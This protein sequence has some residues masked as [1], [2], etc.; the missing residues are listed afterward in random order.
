MTPEKITTSFEELNEK[1][2]HYTLAPSDDPASELED[3]QEYLSHFYDEHCKVEV[4]IP[5]NELRKAYSEKEIGFESIPMPKKIV[6]KSYQEE[7]QTGDYSFKISVDGGEF[8]RLKIRFER[9]EVGDFCGTIINGWGRF[10]KELERAKSNP[11][12][13]DFRIVVEGD[14]LQA[15]AF[16]FPY[17][18][19]CKYCK[20]VGYKISKE[21]KRSYYCRIDKMNKN[22]NSNCNKIAVKQRSH[23]QI[24]QMIAF[25]RKR[26]GMIEA[27]GFPIEWCGSRGEAATHINVAVKQYFIVHYEEILGLNKNV[28]LKGEDHETLTFEVSGMRFRVQKDA[29]EVL[30]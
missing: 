11:E 7:A 5:G 2:F 3:L 9:K 19:V 28:M 22:Y 10:L 15:I 1:H 6:R 29:V 16:F 24:A 27:M 17:P 25:K 21:K 23:K 4:E 12:I 26:I 20:Y 14:R 13:E 8:K 18:K 30:A